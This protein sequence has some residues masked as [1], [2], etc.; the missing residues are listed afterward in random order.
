MDKTVLR[1]VIIDQRELILDKLKQEKI[2]PREGLSRCKRYLGYPNILLITGLR[3]AGKSF[4]TH[5]LTGNIK[6]PFINFDDERLIGIG[7]KDLNTVLECF[8][9]LYKDFE[10]ILLDEIQNIGGWE[11]F[12]NRLRE[13]YKIIITGSNASLLSSELA[14]HLTGRFNTFTIFP[15][16]F[17]EFLRFSSFGLKE[18]LVYSTKEKAEITRLFSEYLKSGGVFE[19]YKFGN[20]FLRNLF[21]SIIAKDVIVRFKPRYPIV[22]EELAKLLLN[23]F[24]SRISSNNISKYL[25]VKSPH[26]IKEYIR[27]LEDTFLIFTINKFSYKIK[28]QLA[29]FKKV[30]IVDNGIINSMAFSFSENKG[31]F[32]ENLVA[33]EL[34]RRSLLEGLEVF[35]WDNYNVECD[36]IIK[37]RRRIIEAFQVCS[38]LNIENRKREI[39]GLIGA[40]KEFRLKEGVILT[41]STDDEIK[42]EGFK[43]RIIPVWKWLLK[44]EGVQ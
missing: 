10:Y 11:L 16:N 2:V 42:V 37:S 25:K 17:R 5:L 9:E 43:I 30:Y 26:T 6:C 15:L 36:F 32:L 14:T 18:G 24:A 4:F 31:R 38:E 19:F 12:V 21:S 41:E 40:L 28:E 29:T 33:V 8:Y 13:K 44:N 1:D 7:V 34:K 20:E 22:L 23:Y 27:Y 39:D 3:R 35:Y